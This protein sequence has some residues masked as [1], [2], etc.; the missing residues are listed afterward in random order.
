MAN[1]KRHPPSHVKSELR[2][3]EA[4]SPAGREAYAPCFSSQHYLDG[5]VYVSSD[6][7]SPTP[8]LPRAAIGR[9]GLEGTGHRTLGN[10]HSAFDVCTTVAGHDAAKRALPRERS[11]VSRHERDLRTDVS[12]R[13]PGLSR[14]QRTDCCRRQGGS[15]FAPPGQHF[16]PRASHSRATCIWRM[17][18]KP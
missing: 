3:L 5:S 15:R 6:I 4:H 18:P 13:T 8:R 17:P 16:C 1:R 11:N 2:T 10:A 14:A 12:T 7:R 9:R